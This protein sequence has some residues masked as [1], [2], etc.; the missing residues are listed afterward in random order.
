METSYEFIEQAVVHGWSGGYITSTPAINPRTH[1]LPARLIVAPQ[2]FII[3]IFFALVHLLYFPFFPR[4]RFPRF[5]FSRFLFLSH[6]P[7]SPSPGMFSSYKHFFFF[8]LFGFVH[9]SRVGVCVRVHTC[10]YV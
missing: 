4:T 2:L 10:R 3:Y 7:P 8:F 1:P 6:T 5:F 9:L